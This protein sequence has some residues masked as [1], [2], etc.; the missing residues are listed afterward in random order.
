LRNNTNRLAALYNLASLALERGDAEAASVLYGETTT[1]ATEL[2][3]GD[4]LVGAYAGHGLAALRLA[5]IA[6]ARTALAAA[7]G[8]LGTKQD[9]WFWGRELFES[10]TIR[11]HARDGNRCAAHDR[12]LVAIERLEA[13]DIYA[14]AWMVADCAAEVAEHDETVSEVVE[15]LAE[16]PTVKRFVPLAARFTALLDMAERRHTSHLRS[17]EPQ[18]VG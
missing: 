10:L 8:A 11:L 13:M 2:G 16:H 3:A 1:L 12:F 5:D 14:A 9:W 17:N 4:I 15:R 7:Q 18:L 6:G